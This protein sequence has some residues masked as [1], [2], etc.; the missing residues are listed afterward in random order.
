MSRRLKRGHSRT[1]AQPM[2]FYGTPVYV[3]L[4][5]CD[6]YW[7]AQVKNGFLVS[8]L[9]DE[10]IPVQVQTCTIYDIPAWGQS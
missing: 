8:Y 4:D 6:A 1:E 3:P 9:G 5:G 7:D 10:V 2:P